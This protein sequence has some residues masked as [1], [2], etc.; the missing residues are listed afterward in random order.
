MNFIFPY[1]IYLNKNASSQEI[2]KT[3][4]NDDLNNNSQ[5]TFHS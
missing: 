3:I 4:S 1:I 2:Y 5:R